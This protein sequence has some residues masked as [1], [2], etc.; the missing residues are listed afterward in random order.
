[1]YEKGGMVSGR[2]EGRKGRRAALLV[3][4]GQRVIYIFINNIYIYVYIY[5][6]ICI[7]LYICVYLSLYTYVPGLS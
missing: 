7:I 5:I 1:M 4:D 6:H 3:P 2:K